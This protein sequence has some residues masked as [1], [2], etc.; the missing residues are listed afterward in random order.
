MP[1]DEPE[2]ERGVCPRATFLLARLLEFGVRIAVT[3]TLKR[4][5]VHLKARVSRKCAR[6]IG[7]EWSE[8]GHML[9]RSL[10]FTSTQRRRSLEIDERL[11]GRAP[12]EG[13]PLKPRPHASHCEELWL[14]DALRR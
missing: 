5:V 11:R 9:F 2:F 1:I 8:F 4:E 6:G 10:I 14:P 7:I 12:N 13:H 3:S